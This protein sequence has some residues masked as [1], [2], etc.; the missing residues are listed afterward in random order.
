MCPEP[1][2]PSGN[3]LPRLP[4]ECVPIP[5][6]RAEVR[7]LSGEVMHVVETHVVAGLDLDGYGSP[8]VLV[9]PDKRN[10]NLLTIYWRLFIRRGNCGYELGTVIG[11]SDP[12]PEVGD[13]NGLR[14]FSV[15]ETVQPGATEE[16]L[17]GVGI[18][19][20]TFNGER[21]LGG[22]TDYR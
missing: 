2:E 14:N 10:L 17:Q 11:L 6:V 7:N 19:V 12:F 16:G 9:P 8:V 20:Y 13:S 22:R 5:H 15:V 1:A 3:Q 21:Y 18:T 4:G